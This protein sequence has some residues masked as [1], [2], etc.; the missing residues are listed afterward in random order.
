MPLRSHVLHLGCN[1]ISRI[2]IYCGT[3]KVEK[4]M[5]PITQNL[6]DALK[7]LRRK[8]KD[9]VFWVDAVCINQADTNEKDS[10]LGVIPKIFRYAFATHA[11][12]GLDSAERD[13]EIC[14]SWI[15]AIANTTV[16][17]P[18]DSSPLTFS[19]KEMTSFRLATSTFE[20][21][22][23]TWIKNIDGIIHA[24]GDP[25]YGVILH[26]F[27]DREYFKRRWTIQ[28]RYYAGVGVGWTCTAA[29]QSQGGVHMNTERS[30]TDFESG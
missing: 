10:Q 30:C 26:K 8:G 20:E 15:E 5:L 14:L 9:M 4:V 1:G 19:I 7:H 13:G 27:L 24:Y 16:D 12:L 28:E 18:D 2:A 21:D 22:I 23:P 29:Q 6:H 3:F 17:S 11:W 25:D